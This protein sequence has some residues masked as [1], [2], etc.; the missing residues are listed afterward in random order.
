VKTYTPDELKKTLADH[1]AW[2]RGEAGGT[3]ANL[4]GAN[5]YGANLS[6][7]N[8]W[9]A[10]LYGAN[11]YGANL[12]Q[13]NLSG[14]SRLPESGP[15]MAWKKLRDGAIC[16]LFI[17]PD[18]KRCSPYT[19]RK[20]R[21]E[22]ALVASITAPDG[23]ALVEGCSLYNEKFVYRVGQEVRVTDFNDDRREVCSSG[24]HHFI[25]RA[26]AEAYA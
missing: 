18:A 16:Q 4:W 22:A 26:E 13:A 6:Q 9:G 19:D 10:N 3:Q 23:T 25:E 17:P 11:L 20:C 5:L 24:I 1:A 7:A 2:L 14:H 12:S 8:L 21:A 15:Y